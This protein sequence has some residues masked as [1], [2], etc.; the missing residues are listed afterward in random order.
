MNRDQLIDRLLTKIPEDEIATTMRWVDE[1]VA[2]LT[3]E[4]AETWTA[5]EVAVYIGA[6]GAAAARS[7]LSRWGIEAVGSRRN[8]AGRLLSLYPASEV[9]AAY[10]NKQI[11][12]VTG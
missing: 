5:A 10:M 2:S 12:E 6:S 8:E 3:K 11:R 4:P 9:R 1:Y 7:T